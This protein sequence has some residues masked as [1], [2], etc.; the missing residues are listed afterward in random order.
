ML[1]QPHSCPFNRN[2]TGTQGD[3]KKYTQTGTE[4]WTK[5]LNLGGNLAPPF[6]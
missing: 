4:P 6:G 3:C 2:P 1:L 5:E